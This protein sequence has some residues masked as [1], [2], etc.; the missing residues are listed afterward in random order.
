MN[1]IETSKLSTPAALAR[2]TGYADEPLET[3]LQTLCNIGVPTLFK[4]D[5]GWWVTLKMHV[6]A[7]GTEFKVQSDSDCQTP[8]EAARQ[9]AERALATLK[10][11]AA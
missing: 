7:A 4:M 1:A 3:L 11:W 8:G 2:L 6:A 10:Q 5:R 9:C